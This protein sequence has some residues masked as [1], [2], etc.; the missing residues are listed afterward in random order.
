M[1][2]HAA[3]IT[4]RRLDA[5]ARHAG[6]GQ[7]RCQSTPT[8]QSVGNLP[9]FGSTMNRNVEFELEVSIP[10]V[11]VLVCVIFVDPAL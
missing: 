2:D 5:D 7:I 4:A 9:A 11:I 6:L 1:L 10:A 8:G 3:F